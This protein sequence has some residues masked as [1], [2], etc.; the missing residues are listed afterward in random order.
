MA[1]Q[2]GEFRIAKF[3]ISDSVNPLIWIAGGMKI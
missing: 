2:I 1:L 3:D